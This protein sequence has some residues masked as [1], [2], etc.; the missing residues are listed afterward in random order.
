MAKVRNFLFHRVSPNRDLLWDPM[1]VKL[2][3][4]CLA[5]ISR[6]F[7]IITIE[8]IP[9][10]KKDRN[11]YATI[12]FDDGYKDNI[13]YALP[14]LEKYNIKASFYIV[15]N[16]IDFNTPTWTY[17]LDYLFTHTLCQSIQLNFDFLPHTMR[18]VSFKQINSKIEYAKKLKPIL[19]TLNHS[20]RSKILKE[21][22]LA[23]NDV[24]LPKIMMNWDDLRKLYTL[25][26]NIGSHTV[27]HSMLG[28]MDHEDD[29]RYELTTSRKRIKE[30]L[31]FFPN[32][33][34]YPIGS[35]NQKVIDN[36][37]KV[38]YTIGIAVK[39]DIYQSTKDNIFEI[40]RIELYNESWLKT[41]LRINHTLE[42]IK[43]VFRYK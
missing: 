33:I 43:Q 3:E 1:D 38:G 11:N 30:E 13:D 4:L 19:K 18:D 14:I 21:I 37:K 34:S 2:F 9:N 32:S 28:T 42:I 36:S 31:G 5:Y 15:T 25:G 40:P 26:H 12:S 8:D 20:Q 41:Y 29:I 35:Y 16:C 6:N 39:Q 22:S 23:F 27:T 7:D 17:I 24:E 10:I